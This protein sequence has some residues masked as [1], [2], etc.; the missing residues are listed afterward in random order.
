VPLKGHAASHQV[1][2]ADEVTMTAD[3]ARAIADYF[4]EMFDRDFANTAPS[5]IAAS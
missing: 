3:H 1:P 4:A 2:Q 5:T